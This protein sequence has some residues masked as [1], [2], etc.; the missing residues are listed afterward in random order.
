M[1]GVF[2][3]SNFP[4]CTKEHSHN[5][6]LYNH[7]KEWIMT[8][9]M[10][11]MYPESII[12]SE[13]NQTQTAHIIWFHLG[14]MSWIGKSIETESRMVVARGWGQ[15]IMGN[16]CLKGTQFQFGKLKSSEDERWVLATQQCEGTYLMPLN[17]KVRNG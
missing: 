4:K 1:I 15:G 10:T 14:E 8:H 5:G 16:Y 13:I 7:L 9:A 11:G 17:Y 2:I 6:M 12:L 3:N